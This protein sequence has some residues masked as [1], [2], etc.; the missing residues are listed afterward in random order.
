MRE[1]PQRT[2]RKDKGG[3]FVLHKQKVD[4]DRQGAVTIGDSRTNKTEHQPSE[5]IPS[6]RRGATKHQR[7]SRSLAQDLEIL[8]KSQWVIQG[9]QRKNAST[10][11]D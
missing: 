4:L 9:N 2:T 11:D 1:S 10:F 7:K 3:A 5:M 8:M 6:S